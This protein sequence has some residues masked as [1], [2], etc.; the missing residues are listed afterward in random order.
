MP[1]IMSTIIQHSLNKSLE[2]TE[3]KASAG[4]STVVLIIS[5]SDRPTDTEMERVRDLMSLLRKSYFD[6][7]FAYV[8][9]ELADFQNI[10]NEYL[11]Y[12]ELFL[13]VSYLLFYSLLDST[14]LMPNSF[15]PILGTVCWAL[16]IVDVPNH[17]VITY[18]TQ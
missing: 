18:T 6:V 4:S 8:A 16:K 7:Y 12:S 14:N 17:K 15:V 2:E 3:Q 9:T 13:P 11:D 1:T 5:P 10:N